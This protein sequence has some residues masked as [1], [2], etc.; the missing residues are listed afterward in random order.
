MNRAAK[1]GIWGFGLVGKSLVNYFTQVGY[2]NL[3]VYDQQLPAANMQ[4]DL[5]TVF[6]SDL[7][8]FLTAC[9]YI[10]P[11]PGV[12]LEL[13]QEY[14]TKF[15]SEI[16]LFAQ[17]WQRPVIAITG[18]LG[19]TTVTSTLTD[20]I[21][22]AGVKAIAVGNIGLPVCDLLN[23]TL[24]LAQN[25]ELAVL[26]LSSFQLELCSVFAPDL[27]IWTN[28]YANH[29][30]RHK[31]LINYFNAK[32]Q[33]FANQTKGQVSLLPISLMSDLITRSFKFSSKCY[34]FGL[35]SDLVGLDESHLN[36]L[37][38][39]I[40]GVFVLLENQQVVFKEVKSK[41]LPADFLVQG[42]VVGD[43]N[44]LKDVNT[45][46]INLVILLAVFYLKKL[47]L[48]S[49]LSVK[50]IAHRLERF[51]TSQNIDWYNDSKSTVPQAT[52]AAVQ[53]LA[54]RP[55]IIFLGGTS[56]GVDRSELILALKDRVKIV[57]CFGSEALFLA[58]ACAQ[59]ELRH[60]QFTTLELALDYCLKIVVPGDQVLFSP[61]GASFDLFANYVQ[62]GEIFKQLVL[63]RI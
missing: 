51:Y 26:E 5:Q 17:N 39:N 28:F 36:Y 4:L 61:A 16:D 53:K 2:V 7:N 30:D 15:R 23:P 44:D 8:Y 59:H 52:L 56:K 12:D 27:A 49:N 58:Q 47:N 54:G 32:M 3:L 42:R 48:P 34:L 33:I 60:A 9:E 45:Y 20:L 19:K 22:Q 40:Q 43:L 37:N 21:N 14:K 11:S 41:N 31:T 46:P 55:V 1:I 62:R 10:F 24:S 29:L 38:K 63:S 18:T 6:T 50:P 25:Y 57:I 35:N 13:Y